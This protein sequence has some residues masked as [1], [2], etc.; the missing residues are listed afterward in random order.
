MSN[1]GLMMSK[2]GEWIRDP[3]CEIQDARYG[4]QK[5]QKMENGYEM[6]DTGCGMKAR[7][8]QRIENREWIK[9]GMGTVVG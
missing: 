1:E 2:D 4:M 5:E 7:K 9:G 3:G 8:E 6:R